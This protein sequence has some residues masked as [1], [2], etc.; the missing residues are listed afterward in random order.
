MINVTEKQLEYLHRRIIDFETCRL[1]TRKHLNPDWK[2][3]FVGDPGDC[4]TISAI[5]VLLR[6]FMF[7]DVKCFSN[8]KIKT[9]ITI[10]DDNEMCMYMGIPG[11]KVVYESE[12]LDKIAL[13]H[14]DERYRR[15]VIFVDEINIDMSEARRSSSNLNLNTNMV[16]QELRHLEAALLYTCISEMWVDM[17]I[18]DLTDIFIK[19]QDIALDVRGLIRHEKPGFHARW[20]IYPMSRKFSGYTYN[21]EYRNSFGPVLIPVRDMW[22][23]YNTL[24]IQKA[25]KGSL[26]Y[27][28]DLREPFSGDIEINRPESFQKAV[29][30]DQALTKVLTS[31]TDD[32]EV[33]CNIPK[34]DIW[35]VIENSIPGI[36]VNH[37]VISVAGGIMKNKLNFKDNWD[38]SCYVKQESEK[39]II[40]PA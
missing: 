40:E 25:A 14:F 21:H 37:H 15:S 11:G 26:K 5:K 10:P 31:F 6:D 22:D 7:H 27:G 18:R 9:T 8:I 29:T 39:P 36:E 2:I 19:T 3:G 20:R 30:L 28:S 24:E 13:F 16:G 38:R 12:P 33:G 34:K 32:L 23:V 4:K 35:Q 1:V 17:R